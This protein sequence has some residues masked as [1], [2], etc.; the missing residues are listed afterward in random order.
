MI[1]IN[2][3]CDVEVIEDASF[4][5]INDAKQEEG[6]FCYENSHNNSKTFYSY[7][8]TKEK[9]EPGDVALEASVEERRSPSS[10]E[11]YKKVVK[12]DESSAK[13]H[14]ALLERPVGKDFGTQMHK[15]LELLVNRFWINEKNGKSV[16]EE[17][18][19]SFCVW[20]AMELPVADDVVIDIGDEDEEES[21]KYSPEVVR[22]F[23]TAIGKAFLQS[24]KTEDSVLKD[25]EVI[26]TELPFSFCWRV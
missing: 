2:D 7:D 3:S 6:L 21:K 8:Y 19:L 5:K 1:N 4:C 20:Q 26:Y 14:D 25:A 16:D 22:E 18:L 10:Y 24:L 15:M 12:D 9:V 11:D 17:K 23:L 13:A